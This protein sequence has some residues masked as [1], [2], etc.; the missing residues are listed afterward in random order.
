MEHPRLILF[1]VYA[2][3]AIIVYASYRVSIRRSN[4][5]WDRIEQVVATLLKPVESNQ[6]A[7]PKNPEPDLELTKTQLII[8]AALLLSFM[9]GGMGLAIWANSVHSNQV[10]GTDY[11]LFKETR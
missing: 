7:N 2:G 8:G 11:E 9:L 4:K 5:R 1:A 6:T 3:V 10:R